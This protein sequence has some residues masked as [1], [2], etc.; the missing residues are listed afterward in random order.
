MKL[1]IIL[2][3]DEDGFW[4]RIDNIPEFLPNTFAPTI[5]QVKTNLIEVLDDYLQHEG[6][7]NAFFEGITTE[8]LPSAIEFD[9]VYDLQAFFEDHH[10]LKISEV[11]KLAGLS[12]S[13][14]RQYASGMKQASAPQVK[15]IESA[16]HKLAQS[17]LELQLM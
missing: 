14:V 15:K 8:S 12:P 3:K 17:L 5:E 6:K 16:I 9:Y 13:L 4:A 11:A 10:A 2:E 7:T 1:T